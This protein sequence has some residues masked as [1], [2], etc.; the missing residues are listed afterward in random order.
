MAAPII[1]VGHRN[2]DNDSISS[3]VGYAYLKNEMARRLGTAENEVYVP[4]RLGPLPPE[5]AW[6]L[7]ANKLPIPQAIPHVHVRV[8]D[9]MTADPISIA[10]TATVLEASRLLRTAN[11]RAIV[12][13]N[14]DGTYAGIISTRNIANRYIAATDLMRGDNASMMKVAADLIESLDEKVGDLMDTDVLTLHKDD[15]LKEA[16]EDMMNSPLREAIVLDEDGFAIGI[17]TRSDVAT[18]PRRKVILVDHNE[19]SQAAMGIEEADVVEIIDHHRI[20]DVS[21]TRPIKFLNIPVG[22]TATIVT[23]EFRNYGVEIPPEIA[24]VLLSA[25]MTDTIILKSPTTTDVDREVADYL[26]NII[27]CDVTAF[28]LSVFKTRGAE[29]HM[30]V[31]ELVEADSKEFM[32]GDATVLIAQHETVDLSAVLSR[33]EEILEHMEAIRRANNYEY[34]L[35]MVTDILAEGSQLLCVGDCRQVNRVFGVDLSQ[36]GGVWMPGILSRKKQVAARVL[37][38]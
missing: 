5:S 1:V 14:D 37:G 25:V 34:V 9:A 20:A 4:M 24:A 6:V 7:K 32:V 8:S 13:T 11:V 3:A 35:L 18:S 16:S 22:S 23:Q 29:D 26:A 17:L 15:L 38:S 33:E 12:V 30:P 10:T 28:G 31:D 21:T 27:G 2:P 19:M 36:P